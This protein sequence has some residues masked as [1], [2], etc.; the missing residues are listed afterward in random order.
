MAGKN[1]SAQG[2]G[3]NGKAVLFSNA[4]RSFKKLSSYAGVENSSAL[5]KREVEAAA[6]VGS[7]TKKVVASKRL[8]DFAPAAAKVAVIE[9]PTNETS[10]TGDAAAV[11]DISVFQVMQ[12]AK[13]CENTVNREMRR[14]VKTIASITPAVVAAATTAKI[15]RRVVCGGKRDRMNGI[16]LGTCEAAAK[17]LANAKGDAILVVEPTDDDAKRL[18]DLYKSMGVPAALIVDESAADDN[19]TQKKRRDIA[20]SAL[21]APVVAEPKLLKKNKFLSLAAANRNATTSATA[22]APPADAPVTFALSKAPKVAVTSLSSIF[23]S[24]NDQHC[25]QYH[26]LIVDEPQPKDE[27]LYATLAMMLTKVKSVFIVASTPELALNACVDPICGKKSSLDEGVANNTDTDGPTSSSNNELP[28]SFVTSEGLPR[29]QTL[30]ALLQN[31]GR[32]NKIVVQCATQDGAIF[33]CE[34][35]YALNTPEEGNFRLF[36]DSENKDDKAQLA[37]DVATISDRF[38]R[39]N[40][41]KDGQGAVLLTAHG[42][43]PKTGTLLVQY[44]PIVSVMN[45]VVNLL[46]PIAAHVSAYQNYQADVVAMAAANNETKVSTPFKAP[47]GSNGYQYRHVIVFFYPSE[48]AGALTL[49]TD[50]L[51]RLASSPWVL[52]PEKIKPVSV[53]TAA[54]TLLTLQSVKDLHKKVFAIQNNAYNAYRSLMQVY[55]RLHPKTVYNVD[56]LNLNAVAAQFGYEELPL[57]DLRTKKTPFRPKLD[58]YRIAA[59]KS[60]HTMK[61]VRADADA[62]IVGAGPDL[63]WMADAADFKPKDE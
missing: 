6:T 16:I 33:L 53:N 51:S 36:C 41:A 32:N 12:V 62:N 58:V 3:R 34:L 9:K 4:G 45:F 11:T 20:L 26:T 37:T 2:A 10:A 52:R 57:L 55:S 22:A 23:T 18:V 42:L 47:A 31:S 17:L 43:L 24:V 48:E 14:V 56:N 54:S 5:S 25:R 30:L 61:R 13:L 39:V 38:D 59:I 7:L 44:D 29:L 63:E 49:V 15:V 40:V 21:A 27:E 46:A 8:Q 35:L 60:K 1:N 19:A 28:V 50:A